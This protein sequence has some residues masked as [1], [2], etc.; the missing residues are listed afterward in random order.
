M[1]IGEKRDLNKGRQGL[2][3]MKNWAQISKVIGKPRPRGLLFNDFQNGRSSK[4]DP[5][6]RSPFWKMEKTQVETLVVIC[7]GLLHHKPSSFPVG[8]LLP[9]IITLLFWNWIK[10]RKIKK[11]QNNYNQKRYTYFRTGLVMIFGSFCIPQE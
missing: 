11:N 7:R 4:E 6:S 1:E 9:I 8:L 2:C 3:M 10:P 5:F